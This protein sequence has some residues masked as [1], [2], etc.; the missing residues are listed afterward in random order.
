MDFRQFRYFITAAEEMHFARAAERLGIAQPAMSQQIKV[1]E[2]QL[3]VLLFSRAK[4]RVELTEAGE[5]FLV[6]SRAAL[7][8][9]DKAVRVAQDTAR[10]E[11]GR[12]NIGFVGSVMYRPAF[13]VL[14]RDYRARHP[15]VRLVLHEMAILEQ[16]ASLAEQ[17]IDIAIVRG[18]LPATVQ[19]DLVFFPLARHKLVAAL[20]QDHPL[21][22]SKKLK[23]GQLAKEAFLALEDTGDAG[24]GSSLQRLCREAGFEPN[25]I[26]R[27]SEVATM[28]SM[29]G[30]GHGVSIVPDLVSQLHLPG[31]K[32]LPFVGIEPY[33]EL[34]LVHRRYERSPA[35]KA[36]LASIREA[37]PL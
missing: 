12:I 36:L 20:P 18:P 14:L 15:G 27:L 29:V 23:V 30:A 17:H 1:L 9:F 22:G 4:K 21:A 10:G 35:V 28:V 5:A 13:S 11:T 3:G 16:V 33:S 24:L 34:I 25:I 6:E 7:A 31:V 19:E 32:Y 8:A 2:D 26:L 37:L